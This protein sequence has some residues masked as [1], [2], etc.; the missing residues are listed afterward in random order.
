M[1]KNNKGISTSLASRVWEA[2][3]FIENI[4]AQFQKSGYI[5]F[6]LHVLDAEINASI[7][8]GLH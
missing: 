1:Q 3:C 2:A 8:G 4:Q 5:S 6:N 7:K